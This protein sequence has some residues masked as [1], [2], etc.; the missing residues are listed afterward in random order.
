LGVKPARS[1]RTGVWDF[2]G[3]TLSGLSIEKQR[4][5]SRYGINSI[6]ALASDSDVLSG[7]DPGGLP[8]QDFPVIPPLIIKHF[9]MAISFSRGSNEEIDRRYAKRRERAK[10]RL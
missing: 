6:H 1:S 9:E 3:G 7:S 10:E 2:S 5:Y 8:S 4:G